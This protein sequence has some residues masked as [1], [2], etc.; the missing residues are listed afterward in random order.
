M[1][2]LHL[3]QPPSRVDVIDWREPMT[4]PMPDTGESLR[5]YPNIRAAA[6]ILGVSASTLSRRA[7]RSAARRGERDRVLPPAEVLRLASIFRR[8][9]M[10]DVA[11]ALLDHARSAAPDEVARVE[12]DIESFFEE[13]PVSVE[14]NELRRLARQLLP[15][16]LCEQ[17]EAVLDQDGGDLPDIIQGY[18]PLPEA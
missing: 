8:R 7:D 10:N 2:T 5:A 6:G 18:P 16:S 15:P 11:Q 12:E 4:R 9:S 1:Q 17:I 13:R 14:R 3:S